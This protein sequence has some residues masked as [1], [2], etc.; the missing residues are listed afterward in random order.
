M[1]HPFGSSSGHILA[2]KRIEYAR[3]LLEEGDKQSAYDLVVQAL[4]L[5]PDWPP[6]WFLKGEICLHLDDKNG[7]NEAFGRYL[8][9]DPQDHMGASI[10]LSLTGKALNPKDLPE[11]Y[12]ES[13]FDQYAIK[14]D[15]ALVEGLSYTTPQKIADMIKKRFPDKTF[16]H[17]LDLG[18]GTGLAAEWVKDITRFRAGVDIS[19]N[20]LKQAKQK[21]LYARLEKDTLNN[22]LERQKLQSYDLIIA[23]D[24]FVY[25]G[26]LDKIIKGYTQILNR[27]GI[28]VFSVQALNEEQKPWALG[29]DHRYSHTKSYCE[30][31]LE[32]VGVSVIDFEKTILRKD[33]HKEIEGY[34]FMAQNQK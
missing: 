24:V 20:M 16:K 23:A 31:L 10:K 5:A 22:F 34:I 6:L 26:C 14:F 8:S 19:E 18:S 2:D 1:A 13:L 12:I 33:G 29:E 28:F 27:D 7:A 11:A 21:E 30:D 17:F 3:Q 4:D 9:L 32:K 15:Q 25:I